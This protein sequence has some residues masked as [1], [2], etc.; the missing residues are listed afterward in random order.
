MSDLEIQNLVKRFGGI[1]AVDGVSLDLEA[2]ELLAILG[3]S[4][5]GKTTLLRLLAG[6]ET[7]DD[8]EIIVKGRV[9]SSPSRVVRPEH[10]QMGMVFQQ[11]VLW[12]HMDVRNNIAYPLKVQGQSRSEIDKA[13]LEVLDVVGLSF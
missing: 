3:P 10:R 6:F 7:P 4:G 5:C 1:T 12:P 9:L 13:V 2:G 8:G 11:H